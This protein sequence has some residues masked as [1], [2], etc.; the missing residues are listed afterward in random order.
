MSLTVRE[1]FNRFWLSSFEGSWIERSH[2]PRAST[3]LP[4][5]GEWSKLES[6]LSGM[7][8]GIL[9]NLDLA[10]LP[11]VS[12]KSLAGLPLQAAKPF[13]L[14]MESRLWHGIRSFRG[15]PCRP[16]SRPTATYVPSVR[17]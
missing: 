11:A 10:L 13:A 6:P 7:S 8:L 4:D 12:A 9:S 16:A 17:F 15:N 14:T 5:C 2:N 3:D 1:C